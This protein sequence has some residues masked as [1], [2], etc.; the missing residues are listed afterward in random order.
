M[1][2]TTG[3]IAIAQLAFF[4]IAILPANYCLLKHGLPGILGW[5]FLVMFCLIRIIGTAIIVSDESRNKPVSQ[6]GGI[7]TSIAIAPLIIA[8]AGVA[9]ES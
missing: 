9:H 3:H 1:F 6:A 4:L 2:D 8:T 7:I 5:L